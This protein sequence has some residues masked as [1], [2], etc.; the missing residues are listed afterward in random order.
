M[1][2]LPEKLY[3]LN[4]VNKP[5]IL[6]IYIFISINFT[7]VLF[8]NPTAHLIINIPPKIPIIGSKQIIPRY[9]PTNNAAIAKTDVN[10]SAK[11]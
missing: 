8:N 10:A 3:I 5:I 9:F 2:N 6:V 11:I 4:F 1:N 7:T